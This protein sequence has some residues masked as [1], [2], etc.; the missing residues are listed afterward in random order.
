MSEM[1][2]A[3][4]IETEDGARIEFDSRGYALPANSPKWDTAGTMRFVTKDK[5]YEWLNGALASWHGNFDPATFRATLRAFTT[6]S[7][8]R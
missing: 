8:N 5:R 3:G 6:S 4:V 7:S 1:N 2:L